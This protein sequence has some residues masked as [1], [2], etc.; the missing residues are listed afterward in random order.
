MT[1]WRFPKN[2]EEDDYDMPEPSDLLW[3]QQTRT[4]SFPTSQASMNLAQLAS[5]NL[6]PRSGLLSMLMDEDDIDMETEV[7][8]DRSTV[9]G[10]IRQSMVAPAPPFAQR[11]W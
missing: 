4:V 10:S 3:P 9:R 1:S 11:G 5:S 7:S 8:D 2:G 6:P